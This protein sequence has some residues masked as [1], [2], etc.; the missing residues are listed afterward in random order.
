MHAIH[1]AA[2]YNTNKLRKKIVAGITYL[3]RNGANF[4]LADKC[5]DTA[6]S[7]ALTLRQKDIAKLLLIH[8]AK[9]TSTIN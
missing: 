4:N 8:G 2:K 6:L 7:L 1:F 9:F 3:V 5:G